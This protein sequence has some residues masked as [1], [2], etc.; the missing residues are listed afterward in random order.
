MGDTEKRKEEA[1]NT[2]A[3]AYGLWPLVMINS[4]VFVIFAFSFTHPKT[5]RDWRSFGAFAAFIVAL[6]VEMYGI[7]LT[8]FFLSGWLGSR[9]PGIDLYSHNAGHLWE[10]LL[11]WQGDPHVSP[12]HIVS[13]ALI[14]GGFLILSS[15]WDV[16]YKAQKRQTLATT[17]L[18]ARIR[19]PQYAGFVFIMLGFL[20]QWPTIL[21]I[22]MFPVLVFMY[23]RLAASEE[24]EME[25]QFGKQYSEYKRKTPKFIPKISL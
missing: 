11:G 3:P 7:P 2:E 18:Y 9:I 15:A 1:M 13:Y 6:F 4:L 25:K 19:H 23:A 5:S 22:L 16:L 10:T 17:G 12:F 21:T 24:N 8:I 20:V 14:F